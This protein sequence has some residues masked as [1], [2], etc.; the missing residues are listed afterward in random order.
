[1]MSARAESD[2]ASRQPASARTSRRLLL[3]RLMG[4]GMRYRSACA[5]MVALQVLLVV[6]ALAGL[7]LTGQGIDFSRALVLPGSPPPD[8]P[9]GWAPPAAWSP[10]KTVAAIAGSVL[11]VALVNALVRYLA[12]IATAELTQRILVQLRSDVYAKL[13]RLSF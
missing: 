6:L 10:L 1:M 4:L 12:A 8:W 2:E 5:G 7:G 11:T 3:R 9:L 13:Q